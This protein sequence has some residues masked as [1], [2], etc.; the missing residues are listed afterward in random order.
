MIA[1][2]SATAASRLQAL[3]RRP[4][5]GRRLAVVADVD[6]IVAALGALTA[7]GY[8]VSGLPADA[9]TLRAALVA[10]DGDAIMLNDYQAFHAS[11]PTALRDAV[12]ARWGA[13]ERDPL[14][15][16]GQV[17]C[18]RFPVAAACFGSVTAILASADDPA[19]P[20]RH[21]MLARIAWISDVWR[22]EAIIAQRPLGYTLGLPV[23]VP[24]HAVPDV[25]TLAAALEGETTVLRSWRL[26]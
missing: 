23:L 7:A 9:A 13:A 20:P 25:A 24:A 22:A 1:L 10:S 18:G 8:G 16:P 14:F 5:A 4:R 11:L 17:D 12:A 21:H 19:A 26:T 3:S 15:R 2:H 6:L